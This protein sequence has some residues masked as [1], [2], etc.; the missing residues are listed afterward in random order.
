MKS[1]LPRINKK[2]LIVADLFDNT[3]EK[4]YWLSQTPSARLNAIECNRRMIYGIH[5]TSSRLQRF[6]EVAELTP[7]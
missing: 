4:R 7:G 3:E 2:I 1:E 6:L 5:R